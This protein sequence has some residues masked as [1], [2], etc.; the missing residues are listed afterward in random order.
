MKTCR[1]PNCKL[2]HKTHFCRVCH[3]RDSHLSRDCW[4]ARGKFKKHHRISKRNNS[5]RKY[6][7]KNEINASRKI[8]TKSEL[9]NLIVETT[10]K[11]LSEHLKAEEKIEKQRELKEMLKKNTIALEKFT[12]ERSRNNHIGNESEDQSNNSELEE[13]IQSEEEDNALDVSHHEK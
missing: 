7:G 6:F 1:V 13:I 11:C 10:S 8:M 12:E 9:T 4:E 5:P 2:K 3:K